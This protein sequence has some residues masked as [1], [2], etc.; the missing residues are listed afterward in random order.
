MKVPF[1]KVNPSAIAPVYGSQEAAA[2]DVFSVEAVTILPQQTICIHTGIS[3]AISD[4]HCLQV[5][6]RS[7]MG[8]KGIHRFAGLID[9]DYRG[10]IKI[11]LYNSTP[12]NYAVKVGDKIAQLAVVPCLRA[13]FFEMDALPATARGSGGFGSTGS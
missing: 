2:F 10:E 6:D 3:V 8:A 12:T 4:N 1:T 11:V 7:S 5:W 9:S 13:V